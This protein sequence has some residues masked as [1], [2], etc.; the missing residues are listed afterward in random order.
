MLVRG[1]A[2]STVPCRSSESLV[3]GENCGEGI[4]LYP[5]L[6]CSNV[7]VLVFRGFGTWYPFFD[8]THGMFGLCKEPQDVMDAQKS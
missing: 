3:L 5:F 6:R 7:S 4:V 2:N 8:D 1:T